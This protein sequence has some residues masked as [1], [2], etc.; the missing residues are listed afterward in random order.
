MA[1]FTDHLLL[2]KSSSEFKNKPDPV[3]Y[4]S[5]SVK[6]HDNFKIQLSRVGVSTKLVKA[7]K[8]KLWLHAICGLNFDTS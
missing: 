6:Q 4:S 1:Q 5:S 2:Y 8:A 7:T 3:W